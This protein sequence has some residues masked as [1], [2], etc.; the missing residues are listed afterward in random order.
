MRPSLYLEKARTIEI[1]DLKPFLTLVALIGWCT[2]AKSQRKVWLALG[3][4]L[5]VV[6]VIEI[7]PFVEAYNGRHNLWIYNSYLTVQMPLLVWLVTSIAGS[8]LL[9]RV[10]V[11]FIVPSCVV[12]IADLHGL[13]F[14]EE[15]MVP[16]ALV[17]CVLLS[18]LFTWVL[19]DLAQHA[20][21]PLLRS[22]R[23]WIAFAH[24]L[25][26][27][28]TIPLTGLFNYL[29]ERDLEL[30]EKLYVLNDIPYALHYGILTW[31]LFRTTRSRTLVGT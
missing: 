13:D 21:D 10:A 18:A 28:C 20:A 6:T 15:M 23:F 31:A 7:S 12:L 30:A 22:A 11:F 19:F 4:H 17:N 26:F 9:Q 2:L 25:F 14:Q 5:L 3:I 27:G 1:I 8:R 16:T 29:M 24:L